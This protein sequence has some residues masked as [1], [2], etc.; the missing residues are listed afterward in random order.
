MLTLG[1]PAARQSGMPKRPGDDREISRMMGAIAAASTERSLGQ[2]IAG[3]QARQELAFAAPLPGLARVSRTGPR[4][5]ALNWF[6]NGSDA[7]VQLDL[8]IKDP[9]DWHG[10]RQF[11]LDA[12]RGEIDAAPWP[13]RRWMPAG[14]QIALLSLP[15]DTAARIPPGPGRARPAPASESLALERWRLVDADG[16]A[17]LAPGPL[18]DLSTRR[19]TRYLR[20]VVYYVSDVS[21]DEANGWTLHAGALR[22]GAQ[23]HVNRRHCGRLAPATRTLPLDGCLETG[24]NRLEVS[25]RLADHNHY[26]GLARRGDPNWAPMR[27][28]ALLPSGLLGPVSLQR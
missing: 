16:R 2:W 18:S 6:H 11:W 27:G 3:I 8:R 25:V 23:V 28:Q 21:L 13:L 20:G 24:A 26:V 12:E 9:A 19:R 5:E 14:S 22:G 10:R 1:A 4:Q 7:A 15:L 17:L